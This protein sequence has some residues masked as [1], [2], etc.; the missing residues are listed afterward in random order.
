[1]ARYPT[2][3][4]AVI[5]TL[6]S[7]GLSGRHPLLL[8]DKKTK[9]TKNWTIAHYYTVL[10][11]RLVVFKRWLKG[12]F[13]HLNGVLPGQRPFHL[14]GCRSCLRVSGGLG[15]TLEYFLLCQMPL[16]VTTQTDFYEEGKKSVWMGAMGSGDRLTGIHSCMQ[17]VA[18]YKRD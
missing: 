12:I 3:T 11:F 13:L 18:S 9:H 8:A 6:I 4:V 16:S 15:G 14:L 5:K 7:N 1:M 17:G 10:P 2:L